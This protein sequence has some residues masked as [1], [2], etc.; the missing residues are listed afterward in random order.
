MTALLPALPPAVV[1]TDMLETILY[2]SL[3][4]IGISVIFSIGILGATKSIDLARAD[5]QAA[6]IA[7]AAVGIL[8]VAICLTVVAVGTYVMAIE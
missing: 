8:A 7:A 3:A 6:S 2:A 4:G 5:R 1:V